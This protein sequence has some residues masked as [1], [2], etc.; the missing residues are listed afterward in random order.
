VNWYAHAHAHAQQTSLLQS[1]EMNALFEVKVFDHDGYC[2]GQ[3]TCEDDTPNEVRYEIHVVNEDKQP[4]KQ[5]EDPTTG[6]TSP[7]GSGYCKGFGHYYTHL[8]DLV[9]NEAALMAILLKHYP[10]LPEWVDARRFYSHKLSEMMEIYQQSSTSV[11]DFSGALHC[12]LESQSRQMQYTFATY[13]I[14]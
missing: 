3:E 11:V 13:V 9:D 7:G 4:D 1:I 6:C 8:F 12:P 10:S 2:S 5:P 14:E